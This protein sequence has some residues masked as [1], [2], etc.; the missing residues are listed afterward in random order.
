MEKFHSVRGQSLAVKKAFPKESG[1]SGGGGS[2]GGAS[3]GVGGG[4]G[5][6]G[7]GGGTSGRGGRQNDVSENFNDFSGI[8]N[9]NLGNFA[10][11]AQK[12]FEAAAMQNLAG[13]N[14]ENVLIKAS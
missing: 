4:G 5:F 1:P 7:G 8:S 14:D 3:G 10:L 13:G 11:M 9:M 12:I 6:G 2:G